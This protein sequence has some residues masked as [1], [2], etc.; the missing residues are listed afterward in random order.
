MVMEN[1][2]IFI[3]T[4]KK[5]GQKLETL[6]KSQGGILRNYIPIQASAEIEEV[7]LQILTKFV[8]FFFFFE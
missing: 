2:F 1:L 8:L 3:K 4:S 6:A 5:R 7:M